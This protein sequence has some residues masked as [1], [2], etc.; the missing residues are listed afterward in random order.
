MNYLKDELADRR[1]RVENLKQ[2]E[3]EKEQRF[4][5]ERENLEIKVRVIKEEI[6]N[7]SRET[8]QL[9]N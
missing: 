7:T 2:I 3:H 5:E 4:I 6:E 8:D 1:R 9:Q